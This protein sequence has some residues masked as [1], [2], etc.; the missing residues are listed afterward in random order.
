MPVAVDANTDWTD[1]SVGTVQ[2]GLRGTPGHLYCWGESFNGNLGLGTTTTQ[3]TPAQVGTDTWKTIK[4][5]YFNACG[6]RSDNALLCWGNDL[7]TNMSLQYGDTPQ[8]I[9]TAIDWQTISMSSDGIIGLRAGGTA[10]AWGF[11]GTGQL[12]LPPANAIPQPTPLG[13]M[14]AGWSQVSSG[15]EHSC[16]IANGH[17]YCWGDIGDGNLGNGASTAFYNPTKIG[18]DSWTTLAGGPGLCGLRSDAALMCWGYNQ[19]VGIA[20]TGIGFGNTDP[21]WA[22][23]RLGTDTWSA[24]ASSTSIFGISASCAIR[25]GT[26]Y[27]WGDNSSGELGLGNTT[28]PQLSPVAVNVPTGTQWTEIAI[29]DHTCA[30]KSDATLWCW[31]ANDTGQ[32]GTGTTSDAP[33]LAPSSPLTGAWLHVAVAQYGFP[34]SMTCAIK[35]DH[36]LWCW[37]QDPYPASTQHLVPTQVGTDTSWVSRSMANTGNNVSYNLTLGVTT[38]AVKLDGTLWCWGQWLGDGTMNPSATPVQVGTAIDW[39]RVA[40]GGEICAIKTGGT[41]WC[42]GNENILGNGKPPAYDPTTNLV[43][44]ATRPTQIGSDT[45]WSTVVTDGRFENVSCATKTD[46]SL[47]CWGY[48][49]APIP[50]F[51]T[52]PVPIN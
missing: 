16:G 39:K 27:C 47:W 4:T 3:A 45:D 8:Q 20:S 42:W 6:I 49:A 31:G 37:G 34:G 11:N 17:A 48:G 18:S 9:G 50:G 23:T 44:T 21:V 1:I 52:M 13:E 19:V 24:V 10:Y 40:V 25:S 5:G 22:P 28:T 7:G 15:I 36:T 12:G 2:C 38:C 32:L 35:T 14:V 30:I 46:G 29:S 33:T 26:P 43:A 51:V 41:L